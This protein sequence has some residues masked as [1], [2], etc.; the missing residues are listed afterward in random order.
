MPSLPDETEEGSGDDEV[1]PSDEK[2]KTL[3]D[4]EKCV[5]LY[6]ELLFIIRNQF[7][8]EQQ[9]KDVPSEGEIYAYG[10]KVAYSL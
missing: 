9:R 3:T 2:D 7:V 4:E 10:Q 1:L 5:E 6:S 8:S